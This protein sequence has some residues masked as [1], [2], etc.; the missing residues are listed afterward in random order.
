MADRLYVTFANGSAVL[1]Q[2]RAYEQ[3]PEAAP[4]EYQVGGADGQV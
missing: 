2:P 1:H 3:G 4:H